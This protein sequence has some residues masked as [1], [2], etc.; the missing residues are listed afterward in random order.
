MTGRALRSIRLALSL[1]VDEFSAR[2][3]I[4]AV[5]LDAFERGDQALEPRRLSAALERLA[6]D[7]ETLDADNPLLPIPRLPLSKHAAN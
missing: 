1:T 2:I 5:E 7:V 3:G 4:P 6:P